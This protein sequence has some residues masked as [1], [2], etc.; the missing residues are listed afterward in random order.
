MPACCAKPIAAG[1]PESGT[2]TTMSAS[3]GLSMASSRA[4]ALAHVVDV[5]ALDRGIRPREID[6]FEDAEARFLRLERESAL[7]AL[8]GDDHH[9]A[10]LQVAH[11]ARAD[12]VERAG[13][14][15]EDPGAVEIA[16]HQRPDAE[17]VA[18]RRSSSSTVS[19]T[20]EKAPS[21]WRIASMK[22]ALMSR[23]LL[24][25]MRCRM[26]SVSEVDEK[27]APCFCSAR[28]TVMALV[29]L[30]LWA[31]ARPPSASSAKKRLHV[32]QAGAAGGGVARMA[33]GAGAGQPVDDGRLGEGVADQADMAL[34]VELRAV[35]GDD[36]GRFLAAVL[37]RVQAERDDRRGVLPAENAEHAAF[38]VE[39]VVGL[40]G[41]TGCRLRAVRH[42]AS[43]FRLQ[44]LVI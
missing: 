35:I 36:A 13:L 15:G 24:V 11:E 28:C 25:A 32:A 43:A 8:G 9:L 22:R 12:D 30:P 40:I 14:G 26:V 34:D 1:V 7:D 16:E 18:A 38:V 42:W 23:S 17:R 44:K 3:T 29:M 27:I 37:Q 6:I 10:G 5:A 2:G 39:M 31:M 41:R 19:A 4:D 33:D 21:T 20:S